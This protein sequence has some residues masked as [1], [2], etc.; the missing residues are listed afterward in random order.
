MTVDTSPNPGRT[1]PGTSLAEP[2]RNVRALSREMVTHFL[3]TVVSCRTLPGESL[4]GDVTTVTR[5]CLELAVSMLD[6][7]DAPEKI[8][9]LEH[10]AAQW[11]RE[12]VPIDT[13]HRAMHEGFRLGLDLVVMSAAT[14]YTH[15]DDQLVLRRGDYDDL[16]GGARIVVDI[17]DTMTSAVSKAYVRELRSVVREHHHGVHTMTSALLAG[18]PTSTMARE[19]GIE[20]A[21]RYHVLALAI[22]PHPEEANP[23]VDRNVVARRKLRRVQAALASAGDT[24]LSL[25]S[26]D[27]GTLLIPTTAETV[28][29]DR[30]VAMLS[31]AGQVPITAAVVS[32]AAADIPGAADQAHQL[33][34]MVHRLR[35]ERGLYR[36]DDLAL[37]YQL[38]RPGPGREQL[39]T[40]LDPLDSHPELLGTLHLHI[41]NNLNR[42]R[43]AHAL[44]VHTNTVDYRLKRI[45][46]ITGFDPSQASGLWYLRS[47][48]VARSYRDQPEAAKSVVPQR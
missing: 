46:A 13:V 40:L 38:T 31:Q 34:D 16:V 11:A 15:E 22:P 44:H 4:D 9:R 33:L 32:V 2:L 23:A 17:L 30:L 39:C 37:E 43:T 6:G 45:A 7:T 21:D 1:R 28:D 8:R 48:L 25:L 26:V 18:H 3:E 27:G 10:A 42:Q 47:A 36:F 29:L 41:S 12:G 14:G 19:S 20:I 35:L 24:V 5:M